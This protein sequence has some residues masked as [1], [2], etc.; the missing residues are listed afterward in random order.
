[1][2]EK[3]HKWQLK[4]SADYVEF[5]YGGSVFKLDL[6][7]CGLPKFP[8]A[9]REKL[10]LYVPEMVE[11][12]VKYRK[13]HTHAYLRVLHESWCAET[14][15]LGMC[16]CS[17]VINDPTETHGWATGDGKLTCSMCFECSI[18]EIRCQIVE[19]T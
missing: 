4:I 11:K 2:S 16:N 15:E 8:E 3:E 12:L 9:V 19:D 13:N 6:D 14:A 18:G 5:N 17:P 7:E 10:P 1:M